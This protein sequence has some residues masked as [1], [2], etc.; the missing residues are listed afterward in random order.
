MA[1]L[2][3]PEPHKSCYGRCPTRHNTFPPASS[4]PAP[5]MT[6][7]L[8]LK[9]GRSLF[10]KHLDNYTPTDPLYETYVDKKGKERRRRVR[11]LWFIWGG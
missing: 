5:A 4:P 3:A 7:N 11:A 10:E 2:L 6:S 1:R 9:V 8:A